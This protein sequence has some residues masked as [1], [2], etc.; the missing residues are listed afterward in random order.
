MSAKILRQLNLGELILR[1]LVSTHSILAQK[2]PYMQFK[3]NQ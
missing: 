2:Y 3:Q 1:Q